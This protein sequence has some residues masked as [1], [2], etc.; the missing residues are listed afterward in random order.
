MFLR[1]ELDPCKFI[2]AGLFDSYSLT[3]VCFCNL[4]TW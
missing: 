4:M 2:M 3:V 1:E